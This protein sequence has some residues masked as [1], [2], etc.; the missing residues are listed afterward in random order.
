[1][2]SCYSPLMDVEHFNAVVEGEYVGRIIDWREMIVLQLNVE[3][4][5]EVS[6]QKFS[7]L[8]REET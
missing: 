7:S 3:S 5:G 1:M 2:H 6:I 4:L 8:G